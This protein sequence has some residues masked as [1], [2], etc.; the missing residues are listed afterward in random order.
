MIANPA[1]T[2]LRVMQLI[3]IGE[4]KQK[5]VLDMVQEMAARQLAEIEQLKTAALSRARSRH[6]GRA[7]LRC[8]SAKQAA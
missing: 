6:T 3:Q 1:S 8:G 2:N 7:R 4:T 5:T